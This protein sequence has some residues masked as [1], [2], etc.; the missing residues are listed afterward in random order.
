VG[1]VRINAAT[2][3]NAVRLLSHAEFVW[4]IPD[5]IML[6]VHEVDSIVI[7]SR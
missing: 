2:H 5:F 1:I 7:P 3:T 4:T 6:V